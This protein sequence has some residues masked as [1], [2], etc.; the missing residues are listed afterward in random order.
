MWDNIL[1]P[2]HRLQKTSHATIACFGAIVMNFV[3]GK[4]KESLL[5]A[6]SHSILH[7][8][9]KTV[10]HLILTYIIYS[11]F[12]L[13]SLL[14]TLIRSCPTVLNKKNT[15]ILGSGLTPSLQ[16]FCDSVFWERG[17]TWDILVCHAVVDIPTWWQRNHPPLQASPHT[18]I[19]GLSVS[20]AERADKTYY[21]QM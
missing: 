5:V 3:W 8:G 6:A 18:K 2:K 15:T 9:N 7:R 11:M 13:F 21:T 19:T 16:L 20:P 1:E 12:M 4:E 10:I 17:T 14:T